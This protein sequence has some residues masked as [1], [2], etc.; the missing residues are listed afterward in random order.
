ME[1]TKV[2]MEMILQKRVALILVVRA[3]CFYTGVD[4]GGEEVGLRGKGK[5]TIKKIVHT[6]DLLLSVFSD[7]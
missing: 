3:S 7:Q 2:K 1:E 5:K 4:G 6:A